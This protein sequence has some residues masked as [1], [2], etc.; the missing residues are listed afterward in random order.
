MQTTISAWTILVSSVN[1]ILK[2]IEYNFYQIIKNDFFQS[3][4]GDPRTSVRCLF[5]G[6]LAEAFLF[7]T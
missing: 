4:F 7:F 6:V 2:K 5:F 3:F 1:I